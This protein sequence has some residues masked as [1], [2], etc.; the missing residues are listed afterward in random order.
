M[1][2]IVLAAGLLVSGCSGTAAEPKAPPV[3]KNTSLRDSVYIDDIRLQMATIKKEFGQDEII[4]LALSLTNTSDKSVTLSFPTAQTE[5]FVAVGAD[6]SQKWQ[7][8]AG[9]M[10]AQQVSSVTIE[11][12]V[13]Q[14]Y[15]GKV[16]KGVLPAGAYVISGWSTAEELLGERVEFTV[17]VR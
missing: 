1:A 2:A 16:E 3:V 13:T 11:P 4:P 17:I 7:W 14:N 15:F 6:G 9:M 8:S 12:G 10:Y 5:D